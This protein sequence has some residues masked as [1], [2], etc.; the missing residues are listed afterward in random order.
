M[1]PAFSR[2]LARSCLALSVVIGAGAS[3]IAVANPERTS[4]PA[5]VAGYVALLI[6]PL[7]GALIA[8]RRPSSPIGW[9]LIVPGLALGISGGLAN[10][11]AHYSVEVHRLPG[12]GLLLGITYSWWAI[13]IGALAPF[14]LLLFPDGRPPSPRWRWILWIGGAGILLMMLGG[15][16]TRVPEAFPHNPSN[17]IGFLPHA[18]AGFLLQVGAILFIPSADASTPAPV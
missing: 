15:M 12:D 5:T 6:F 18:V 11:Y 3:A 14:T 13:A 2:R 1:T 8:S 7:V 9:L 4:V 10:E 16:F 17:P